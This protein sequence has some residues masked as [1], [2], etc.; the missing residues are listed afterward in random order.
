[1]AV[2]LG[3]AIQAS[4]NH[5]S[6]FKEYDTESEVFRQSFRQFQYRQASGPR[7][8]F[9]NLWELCSQWLKPAVRSKEEILEQLVFEQFLSILPTEI[10]TWVRLYRPENREKV[11]SL[12]EELQKELEGP[13]QQVRKDGGFS[14]I[15]KIVAEVAGTISDV[16][17]QVLF[18]FFFC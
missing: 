8:A 17:S 13:V 2:T 11:L 5:G 7:E 15:R 18:T 4:L 9:N 14:V 3:C 16:W 6:V 10:E 12:V 1:M